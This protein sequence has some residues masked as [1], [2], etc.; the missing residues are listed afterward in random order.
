[1]QG[2]YNF[3]IPARKDLFLL[4]SFFIT[5]ALAL[6]GALVFTKLG[7]PVGGMIG[8]AL[9]VAAYNLLFD[10]AFVYS[11]M[12]YLLQVC[13]GVL[14]GSKITMETLKA[15]RKLWKPYLVMMGV[16]LTITFVLS[17]FLSRFSTLD[18]VTALLGMAPGGMTDMTILSTALGGN[19]AYVALIHTI[20][21]FVIILTLP[22]LVKLVCKKEDTDSA[23]E[24]KPA[25]EEPPL[26]NLLPALA[27]AAV[28]AVIFVLLHIRAGAMLGAM[29]GSSLCTIFLRRYHCPRWYTLLL[30]VGA[31]AFVGASVTHD[32]LMHIP[33][34]WLP[35]LCVIV[36]VW[37]YFFLN[38]FLMRRF[39]GMRKSTAMIACAPGGLMEMSLLAEELGG[40]LPTIATMHVLRLFSVILIVP[41]LVPLVELICSTFQ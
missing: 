31:G 32:T 18:N 30:Q 28:F 4:L 3:F 33:H 21:L 34:L 6:L 41:N 17:L 1:M 20:R 25:A 8:A 24:K 29:I 12:T 10:A 2:S 36:S 14:V 16:L 22:P 9:F 40:D 7:V 39:F 35:L 11:D 38:G 19:S 23:A 15:L 27:V 13:S 5:L 37:V 26:R